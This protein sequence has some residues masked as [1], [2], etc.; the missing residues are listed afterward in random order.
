M[1]TPQKSLISLL[2][3]CQKFP[4]SVEIWQSSDKKICL[5]SFFETRCTDSIAKASKRHLLIN[6]SIDTIVELTQTIGHFHL[7]LIGS[8]VGHCS[9]NCSLFVRDVTLNQ[10]KRET[11]DGVFM[12]IR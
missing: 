4:Q 6:S 2:S 10:N 1:S 8:V 9:S 11:G 3:L 12:R 7:H 5:H